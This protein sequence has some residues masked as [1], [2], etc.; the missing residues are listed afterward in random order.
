MQGMDNEGL[1]T[2]NVYFRVQF[3]VDSYLFISDK[4]AKLLYYH[5]MR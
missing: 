3:Y 4:V 5:Q 1:P 2:F